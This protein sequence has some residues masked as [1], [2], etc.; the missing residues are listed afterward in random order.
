MH[1]EQCRIFDRSFD[2]SGNI[3][4]SERFESVEY[5]CTTAMV[6]QKH[7]IKA[8]EE[9]KKMETPPKVPANYRAVSVDDNGHGSAPF[10]IS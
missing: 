10:I 1:T 3:S 7:G 4:K 9:K 5:A 2:E 8:Q 6:K